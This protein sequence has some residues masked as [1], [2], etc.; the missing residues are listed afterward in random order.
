MGKGSRNR[1]KRKSIEE[2]IMELLDTKEGKRVMKKLLAPSAEELANNELAMILFVLD[3][4]FGFRLPRLMKF[5]RLYNVCSFKL[6]Q[7]YSPDDVNVDAD[8]HIFF[9]T[10]Y[11]KNKYRLTIRELIEKAASYPVERIDFNK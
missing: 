11:I 4:A 7:Y 10:E 9:A 3:K 1:E 8:T 2:E 6:K 5:V